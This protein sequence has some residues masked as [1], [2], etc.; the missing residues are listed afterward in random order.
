MY[1][2][3]VSLVKIRNTHLLTLYVAVA[4]RETESPQKE[5]RRSVHE[6]RNVDFQFKRHEES[7]DAG[8]RRKRHDESPDTE[9]RRKR[10]DDGGLAIEVKRHDEGGL[11]IEVKRHDEGGLAIEVKRED[12]MGEA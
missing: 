2:T 12:I 7:P 6:G 8:I 9:V 1:R 11:A 10:H 4:A 5:I 3:S